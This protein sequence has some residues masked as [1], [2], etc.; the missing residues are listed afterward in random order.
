MDPSFGTSRELRDICENSQA[1]QSS[2]GILAAKTLQTFISDLISSESAAE[3]FEYYDGAVDLNRDLSFTVKLE[4]N[5]IIYLGIGHL[6]IP[7]N[8]D[9]CVNWESVSRVQIRGVKID[10][11][12]E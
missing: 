12:N 11:D 5:L 8:K 7:T 10:D 4:H 1:A 9:G 3:L 6:E 2:I